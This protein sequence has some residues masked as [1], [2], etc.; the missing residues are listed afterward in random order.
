MRDVCV[1][2]AAHGRGGARMTPISAPAVPGSQTSSLLL[3]L[4][5]GLQLLAFFVVLNT[6]ASPDLGRT[7]AVVA[8]VQQSFN[9]RAVA[10]ADVL[11]TGLATA[12]A[13]TALRTSISEAFNPV[14]NGQ[15]MIV[16]ADGDLMWVT[17][18]PAAFFEPDTDKLRAVL[19]VLDRVVGVLAQPPAG[20][21]YELMVTI[22]APRDR[23]EVAMRQAGLMA[24]DLLRRGLPPAALSLGTQETAV[25]AV[26]LTFIVLPED[27]A[28][29]GALRGMGRT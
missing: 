6:N 5:I 1:R 20:L 24:E 2:N 28:A 29:L 16:R 10:P 27:A 7:R 25:A 12:A 13:Q 17:S 11:T 19:P 3:T 21:R 18:P 23:A 14:L 9:P 4:S 8:S 26:T 15:D 22:A